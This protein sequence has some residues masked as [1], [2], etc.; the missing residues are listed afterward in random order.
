[1]AKIICFPAGNVERDLAGVAGQR[2]KR[3][4]PKPEGVI[5]RLKPYPFGW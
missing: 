3:N 1:M 2:F 5:G 4:V